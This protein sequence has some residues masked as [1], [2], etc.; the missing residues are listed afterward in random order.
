MPRPEPSFVVMPLL[1]ALPARRARLLADGP[2]GFQE[3]LIGHAGMAE[4]LPV[5]AAEAIYPEA[6]AALMTLSDSRLPFAGT[7]L[8]APRVLEAEVSAEGLVAL[9]CPLGG[10]GAAAS[11]RAIR[12][13]AR[14]GDAAARASAL[15]AAWR[16]LE[17]AG[18][19]PARIA[20]D[21]GPLL[22]AGRVDD[23][24]LGALSRLLHLGGPVLADLAEARGAALGA[25]AAQALDR[26][27]A[28]LAAQ[29]PGEA[30]A[31]RDLWLS[32]HGRALAELAS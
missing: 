22:V 16:A 26:G 18:A 8:N 6:A 23:G 10:V 24:A 15:A 13:T 31:A 32:A 27:A 25:L 12:L 5:E 17:S 30:V 1:R 7:K 21:P 28:L 3:V 2:L 11:A 19:A 14:Q 20:L 29:A 4:T 9:A